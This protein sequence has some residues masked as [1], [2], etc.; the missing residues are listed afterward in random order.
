MFKFFNKRPTPNRCYFEKDRT[1]DRECRAY[2]LDKE[3]C[4]IVAR[5]KENA[6][7]GEAA[8]MLKALC[9]ID[10]DPKKIAEAFP[11]LVPPPKLVYED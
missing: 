8:R 7:S 4:T 9:A 3:R 5:L 10:C 6:D 2:D 1:C 11:E